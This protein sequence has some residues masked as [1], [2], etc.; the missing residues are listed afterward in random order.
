MGVHPEELLPPQAIEQA[1]QAMGKPELVQ[2]V[3]GLRQLIGV[4]EKVIGTD[5]AVRNGG[6]FVWGNMQKR[7][8]DH[9]KHIDD[10][11]N[12]PIIKG[13]GLSM[14]AAAMAKDAIIPAL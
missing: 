10:P 3:A 12:N 5:G 6:S 1:A 9:S 11:E 13:T 14:S 4:P 7:N 8:Y 2:Q